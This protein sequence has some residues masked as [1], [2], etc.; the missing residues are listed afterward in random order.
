MSYQP[1]QVIKL[2]S[3]RSGTASAHQASMSGRRDM[4]ARGTHRYINKSWKCGSCGKWHEKQDVVCGC[5]SVG[6]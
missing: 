5:I 3:Y 4:A 2:A 1:H 6:D